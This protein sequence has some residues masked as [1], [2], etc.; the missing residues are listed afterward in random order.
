[1]RKRFV[2]LRGAVLVAAV[3]ALA[4][5]GAGAAFAF[6]SPGAPPGTGDQTITWTGQGSTGSAPG[7][8]LCDAGNEPT[9]VANQ[10]YMLWILTTDHGTIQNDSTTPTLTLGGSGSGSFQ[11]S[12]PSDNSEAH[13]VTPYFTPDASLQASVDM[14][15]LTLDRGNWNLVLSHGCPGTASDL[16]VSKTATP[17]FIRTFT[18]GITKTVDPS[19]QNV[20]DGTKATFDYQVNV[21]HDDG[22][23]SGWQV[24][25]VITVA[26]PNTTDFTGVNVTDS[27]DSGGTC[28]V[29][30]GTGATIAAGS[31]AD[32][33]Y[34]CTYASAPGSTVK[35]TATATW[36]KSVYNT[37]DGSA[38]GSATA[39]FDQPTAIVNGTVDVSDTLYGPLGTGTLSYTDSSPAT[40]NYPLDFT[41]PAG[42][43]TTHDNTASVANNGTTLA[44]DSKTV[45]VCVGT[46]LTVS[47]DAAPSFTRTYTWNINKTVTP[48]LI[49]QAGGGTATANYTVGVNQTGFSDGDWAVSGTI[50]VTNPNDWESV[51]LTAPLAD[52]VTNGGTCTVTAGSPGNLDPAS[53]T[54]PASTTVTFPY[55]CTYGAAPAPASGTNKATATW[56]A[57][58]AATPDGS[59]QGTADFTFGDPTKRVNQTVTPTDT[60]NG[61]SA[62]QLCS[63]TSTPSQFCTLTASDDLGNLTSHTY[64]YARQITVPVNNCKTYQNTATVLPGHSSSASVKA[65][66]PALTGALTMGFWQ[67]KNGQAII[68]GGSSTFGTCNSATWLRQY[69]PFQ[70][71]NIAATCAGVATYVNNVIKA[72][73]A[74]GA[75]MNAMLKAQM[76]ATALDVYFSDSA[77]GGNKIGAPGPV[78]SVGIDLTKVCA[79]PL[80]CTS[81][82]NTSAAFGGASSLTVSGLLSYA[83]G[84][85]NAGGSI[86]YGQ[87][88]ATQGLAKDTFD[89]INNQVAFG[90]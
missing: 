62:Q 67:N 19:S 89:A 27:S 7:T 17:S 88:K 40:F 70:D 82:E 16:T 64:T 52:A 39:T 53:A 87:V 72:A 11:T 37:P 78:G 77:L 63:L 79:N 34:T 73:N 33:D 75:S 28:V 85:S 50:T 42:T 41:D 25:G 32:F 18:W 9:G 21:T 84:Q 31:S 14:N 46:D 13:F 23:D 68:T 8:V 26:N 20:P 30:G 36:D 5:T 90:A 81:Y 49:E 24:D 58:T 69:A 45:T 60:F 80:T 66:G 48:H 38:S 55:T 43:C 59:A 71:L 2:P 6:D 56:D 22:T 47:K 15:V 1:M 12:N 51:A 10:P 3:S 44:S 61:G 4:L 29:T 74:S 57:A 76:L 35:D 65:C 83:A 86:W 54:I